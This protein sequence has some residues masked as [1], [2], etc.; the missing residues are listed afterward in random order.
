M[1]SAQ[2]W[3]IRKKIINFENYIRHLDHKTHQLKDFLAKTE[4]FIMK[5]LFPHHY[6]CKLILNTTKNLMKT[7]HFFHK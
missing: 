3:I 6:V 5:L 1:L 7:H 2:N 4:L